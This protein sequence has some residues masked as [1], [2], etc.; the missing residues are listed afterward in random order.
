VIGD[1]DLV[2]RF[3]DGLRVLG[4]KQLG[5]TKSAMVFGDLDD[6]WR[7]RARAA[8]LDL[9]PL[10]LQDLFVHLTEPSGDRS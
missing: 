10:A 2:D 1:A 8:G 5:R 9:G 4:T 3:V 6:E 7:G